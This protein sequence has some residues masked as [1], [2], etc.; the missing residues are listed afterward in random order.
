MTKS[1]LVVGDIMIDHYIMGQTNRISP[2]APVQVVEFESEKFILGGAANV[3]NNLMALNTPIILTSIVGEDENKNLLINLLESNKISTS[4]IFS[5]VDRKTTKKTRIFSKHQNLIRLDFESKQD[6]NELSERKIISYLHANIETIEIIII[7]DYGKGLLTVDLT[8]EIIF[9][10]SKNQIK[11]LVD[12]KGQDYSKYKG[13]YVLTPNKVELSISTGIEVKDDVSLLKALKKNKETLNLE[14]S[15]ATLS[16][17]GI[18]LYD[19][20]LRRF[21]TK[22]KEVYDVTGAGDTVIA[23]L[24]YSFLHGKS[25]EESIEFANLAAGVVVGKLGSATA[26]LEEIEKYRSVSTLDQISYKVKTVSELARILLNI[27][28]ENKKIVFTNGCFDILHYGHVRLIE[29]AKK[30]GNILI[31][32]INSDDSVK[33]LKGSLRPI[34]NQEDRAYLLASLSHVDYVTIFS[35]DT[36]LE[37]LNLLKPNILVKGGDYKKEEVVGYDIVEEVVI[38]DIEE[39]RS[40]SNLITKI[41]KI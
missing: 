23:A 3:V 40:S 16:E 33:R 30:M 2:E 38:V 8:K 4:G 20:D 9:I 17:D 6:I 5:E 18:A 11:V 37:I 32:A 36:P 25:I 7:S 39:G 34:N 12:P 28:A 22:V 35:D 27:K 41:S 19:R 15:L 14:L 24:A 1:I 26:T 10:A 29:K 21:P 13:A 31:V